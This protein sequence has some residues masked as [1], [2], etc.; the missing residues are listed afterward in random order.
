MLYFIFIELSSECESF[1]RLQYQ[2]YFGLDLSYFHVVFTLGHFGR[3]GIVVAS[4][5]LSVRLS[6]RPSVGTK[7]LRTITFERT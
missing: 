1:L 3:R 2:T 4:V 7:L 6:V 5:R